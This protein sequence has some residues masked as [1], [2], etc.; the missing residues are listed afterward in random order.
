M[1]QYATKQRKPNNTG[2]PDKVKNGIEG[3]SGMDMSDVKVH[4]N[5]SK[6]A[7]VQA[8]AY[9]Q[10]SNIYVAPG[11]QQHVAHEAWHVVQQKQGRVKPTTSIGGMAVNDNAG[12]ERE[13]DIMGAKAARFG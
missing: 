6:P 8:H 12:L 4:Y 13:A 5:S 1:Y 2:L 9:T 3:L 11:Q 7:T 10:G